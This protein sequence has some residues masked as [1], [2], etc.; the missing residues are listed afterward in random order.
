MAR[1]FFD[2]LESRF[3]RFHD[4]VEKFSGPAVLSSS[5]NLNPAHLKMLFNHECAVVHVKGFY[6]GRA[7]EGLAKTLIARDAASLKHDSWEVATGKGMESSDVRAVCGTP[8]AV[9]VDAARRD[10]EELNRYF[11]EA[12]A[13]LR[14]MRSP[15]GAWASD[16]DGTTS[17]TAL[18]VLSPLDKLRLELD[19][20]W[21]GGATLLKDKVS[22]RPYLPGLGRVMKGPT[23]WAEGFAHV[24]ELSP[25]SDS[26]GLFSANV[27]LQMPPSG[28]ELHVWCLAFKSKWD[29]YRHASTLSLLTTPDS[30]GQ[31]RLRAKLLNPKNTKEETTGRH[32]DDPSLTSAGTLVRLRPE[33]GDLVLL[34]AQRPHAV[35]GFPIGERVS[36]QSFLTHSGTGSAIVI[37][38]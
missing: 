14:W 6:N 15:T 18:P 28:G 25:L 4:L 22:G 8:F 29:F 34:C 10:P 5:K 3:G 37:D 1:A 33:A 2:V 23:K 20:S 36:L 32:G 12:T 16:D 26:K 9:A 27:Y 7:S 24:D 35:Q 38:N 31:R 21:S 17:N 13:E 19:E 11:D 30:E